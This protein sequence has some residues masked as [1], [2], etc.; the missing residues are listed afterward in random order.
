VNE[1]FA[2]SI[3]SASGITWTLQL[4][5]TV[6]TA[7]NVGSSTNQ[8]N[9]DY[10]GVTASSGIS[11]IG[12][13]GVSGFTLEATYVS[14]LNTGSVTQTVSHGKLISGSDYYQIS[15]TFVLA[16]G[17]CAI[18]VKESGWAAFTAA[19]EPVGP[20]ASGPVT[21]GDGTVQNSAAAGQGAFAYQQTPQTIPANTPTL[22]TFDTLGEQFGPVPM[23]VTGDN[24]KLTAPV[25]GLYLIL[26]KVY[27]AA[28]TA[29]GPLKMYFEQNGN[30]VGGSAF[31]QLTTDGIHGTCVQNTCV[32]LL[33][34]GD[35]VQSIIYQNSGESLNISS[36]AGFYTQQTMIYLGSPIL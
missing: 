19:G 12:A 23:W 36:P 20:V 15:P 25:A 5:E 24:T 21:F 10:E 18:F 27:T 32:A 22:V 31:V 1:Q 28:T 30:P 26:A 2:L 8:Q 14:L 13:P 4:Q 33:N 16:P 17:E 29:S 35:Y 34:G 6:S 7:Q 11:A 3:S 9:F